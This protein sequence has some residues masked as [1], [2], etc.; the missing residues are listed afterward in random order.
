MPTF[1][2]ARDSAT[3]QQGEAEEPAAPQQAAAQLTQVAMSEILQLDYRTWDNID[4]ITD[5]EHPGFNDP[6][7]YLMQMLFAEIQQMFV[8]IFISRLIE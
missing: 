1:G 8:R 7:V 3:E 6:N 5:P 4:K 2:R